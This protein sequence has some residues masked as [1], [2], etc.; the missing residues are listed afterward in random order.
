MNGIQLYQI[1]DIEYNDVVK[2]DIWLSMIRNK[3]GLSRRIYARKCE[4]KL[5]SKL[6]AKKFINENHMQGGDVPSNLVFGL[7]YDD[8]LVSLMSFGKSRFNKSYDYE[9]LRFC[10]RKNISV[11]EEPRGY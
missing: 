1:F 5:P 10:N 7:Y 9:L 8:E 2:K 4:I 11:I 6:E 3:L